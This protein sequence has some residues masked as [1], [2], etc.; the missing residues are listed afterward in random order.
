MQH[1]LCIFQSILYKIIQLNSLRLLLKWITTAETFICI[2]KLFLF[3]ITGSVVP[4]LEFVHVEVKL[5][6]VYN[7][8]IY[9][10]LITSKPLFGY[11]VV[12]Q[13]QIFIRSEE[14]SELSRKSWRQAFKSWSVATV[15]TKALTII[16]P[17]INCFT[18]FCFG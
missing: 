6:S 12:D 17:V 11:T 14:T 5:T 2:I 3:S 8:S 16:T 4:H 10:S 7:R 18:S 13:E 9:H 1:W 15:H